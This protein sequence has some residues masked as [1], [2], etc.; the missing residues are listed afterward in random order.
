MAPSTSAIILLVAFFIMSGSAMFIG[1]LPLRPKPIL[2]SFRLYIR[3]PP[4]DLA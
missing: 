1:D 4:F 3:P 2:E